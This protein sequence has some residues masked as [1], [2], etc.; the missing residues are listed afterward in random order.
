MQDLNRTQLIGRLTRDIEMKYTNTGTA[1]G[2][3][4]LAVNERIKRFDQWEERASFFDVTL[5]GKR[6]EGLQQYLTKGKQI[7]ID[8]R[9][10]QDRWEKDGQN[11]SRVKVIAENIQLLGGKSNGQSNTQYSEQPQQEAAPEQDNF[12]DS[13]P[14]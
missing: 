8:G 5:F 14:F 11:R 13:I 12:E 4:S 3:I 2:N 7:A 6:A 1:I 10:Q 9:L